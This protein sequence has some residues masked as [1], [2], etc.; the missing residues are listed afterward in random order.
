MIEDRELLRRYVEDRSEAAFAEIVRRR[1]DLVYSVAR[2]QVGGDTHL[3]EDVTQKVFADLARKATE[4]AGRAV[5]SGW[6]YRSA[7]FAAT[8]VVRSERRRRTREQET[9]IMNETSPGA[10]VAVDWERL[11][12]LLDQA[13]GE[14]GN[15][16]R[17]AVALRFFE[18]RAF[19]EIG[20]ALDLTEEAAR[21]RV[22]RALDKL[23][24]LLARRG[25]TSTAAALGV[26]LANQAGIAAPAG[27]AASVTG[28]AMA[29][30]AA[31]T[32]GWLATFMTI[33][34]LQ[35]GIASAVAAAFATAYVLQGKTNA[36]LRGEIAA[37]Q[38]QQSSM[39]ALHADNQHLADVAAEV[40]MLRH[41]D[42][43]LK[44][45][46][47]RAVEI[48]K[49]NAE[50]ARLTQART[51][52]LRN[53]FADQIR[54]DD[55]RAQQEI[56]R[57][58]REGS[59]LVEEYKV[60]FDRSKDVSLSAEARAQAEAEGKAKLEEVKRTRDEI[61]AFSENT[62]EALTQRVDAFR[63]VYGDDPNSPLAS[64]QIG[65]GGFEV[66]RVPADGTSPASPPVIRAGA[67]QFEGQRV[68]VT[69]ENPNG[70]QPPVGEL[71]LGPKP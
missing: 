34:K 17:D 55:Q 14:L 3:A 49:A 69:S 1:I 47:E 52:D 20:R 46:A 30:T 65:S 38:G 19:A 25:V 42:V 61:R 66:R 58:N 29:G 23:H 10:D 21:K 64:L 57:M 9:Q 28:A 7:Q 44:Q 71:K 60:L 13:L 15:A 51:Q 67:Q 48:K 43:E 70:N 24:A 32:A 33:G 45:L 31:G 11:R 6:L 53:A 37:F 4:L 26:A 2:R 59:K 63:R 62:R 40:E 41:D 50:K 68:P 8:D 16:E 36:A 22:E 56:D 39:A 5:L 12:P 54:A 35:V 27:L 18:G